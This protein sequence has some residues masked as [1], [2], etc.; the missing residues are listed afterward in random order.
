MAKSIKIKDLIPGYKTEEYYAEDY[1]PGQD[2]EIIN[3]VNKD[4]NDSG[5]EETADR[6]LKSYKKKTCEVIERLHTIGLPNK[7]EQLRLITKRSF[8]A[9]AFLQWVMSLEG[10]VDE[11][12]FC[13]YSINH[14]ASVM[15]ND[16]VT[17][18]Q[19]K[20]ATILMSNL[21]NKAHRSKEEATKNYFVKNPNIELIFASSHSKIMSFKSGEN[22]YT[23]EG[24][25]NLSYNSRIEQYIIDND[26]VVFDFTKE[27]I[28]EIKT[29]LMGKKELHI[30]P[31]EK[32]AQ[33]N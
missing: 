9:I 8:N 19:I 12:L 25:G 22:Y 1:N 29:Y 27:W 15:I 28:E 3:F 24:S 33:L 6:L 30:Y 16:M 32:L 31:K 14:E 17:R 5:V 7:G 11:A 2:K 4:T 10:N 13:I 21:R 26:K 20:T 18:G 23:V